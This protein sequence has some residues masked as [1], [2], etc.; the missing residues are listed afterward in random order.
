MSNATATTPAT[1]IEDVISACLQASDAALAAKA[2]RGASL[3]TFSDF[4]AQKG[5]ITALK[6]ANAKARED[7]GGKEASPAVQRAYKLCSRYA[8]VQEFLVRFHL[9]FACIGEIISE[10]RAV[11][12]N[13]IERATRTD[14]EDA[15]VAAFAKGFQAD[16]DACLAAV[17]RVLLG[18]AAE[19]AATTAAKSEAATAQA[20]AFEAAV[21]AAVA[22][23][24]AEQQPPARQR[25][26]KAA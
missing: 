22:A 19:S 7:A 2:A 20:K 26:A 23:K 13:I 15:A 10:K 11:S 18:D 3:V 9:D 21:A 25:V 12:I 16:P 6:K 4:I 1:T 14:S 8:K 5:D 24:L 17:Q